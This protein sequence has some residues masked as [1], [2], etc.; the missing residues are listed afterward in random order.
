MICRETE[1]DEHTTVYPNLQGSGEL[2]EKPCFSD[3]DLMG[4]SIWRYATCILFKVQNYYDNYFFNIWI[5]VIYMDID[6]LQNKIY[7]IIKIMKKWFA[8]GDRQYLLYH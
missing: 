2:S 4:I 8:N 6:V 7:I 1:K 5:L 3:N